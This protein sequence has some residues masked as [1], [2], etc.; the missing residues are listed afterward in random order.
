[1]KTALWLLGIFGV[2]VVFLGVGLTLNPREVPSPL[3]NKA[4]PP[5]ELPQLHAQDKTFSH[6]DMAGK[7][8]LLNVWASRH[9]AHHDD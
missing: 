3:I 2:L 4:A 7:V 1:M 8:W 6:K 9:D 5:F